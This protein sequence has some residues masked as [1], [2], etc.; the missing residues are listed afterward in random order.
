MPFIAKKKHIAIY[1]YIH[2]DSF[3]LK[4]EVHDFLYL[5]LQMPANNVSYK[6]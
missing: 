1:L 5:P 4:L 3:K 2:L 6:L